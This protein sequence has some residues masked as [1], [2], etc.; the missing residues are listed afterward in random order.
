[1]LSQNLIPFAYH[2]CIRPEKTEKIDPISPDYACIMSLCQ[3]LA[4]WILTRFQPEASG[5]ES[6]TNHRPIAGGCR[7]E[8]YVE[9]YVSAFGL[10][11][12]PY[13]A[14]HIP[15][16]S[17]SPRLGSQLSLG[18]STHVPPS[19]HGLPAIPPHACFFGVLHSPG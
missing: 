16:Q 15:I 11:S 3:T 1:M 13:F 12:F 14:S 4:K 19:V 5:N 8:L 17:A 2:E 10:L 7:V 18:S 6:A 9:L